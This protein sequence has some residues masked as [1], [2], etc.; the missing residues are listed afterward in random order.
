MLASF[1][2]GVP[3]V[4]REL[5]PGVVHDGSAVVL[6]VPV[7][8]AA[9]RAQLELV[10]PARLDVLPAHAHV[11]VAVVPGVSV[12]DRQAVEELE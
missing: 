11:L 8:A 6:G 12:V 9:P 3:A 4:E 2:H 1:T 7:A 10:L 5:V